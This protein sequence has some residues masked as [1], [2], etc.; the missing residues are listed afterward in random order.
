MKTCYHCGREFMPLKENQKFCSQSC[1]SKSARGRRKFNLSEGVMNSIT[2]YLNPLP[3]STSSMSTSTSAVASDVRN[4]AVKNA[5][6]Q[7]KFPDIADVVTTLQDQSV[8]IKSKLVLIGLV[9]IGSYAGAKL[10]G[11]GNRLSGGLAGGLL[12]A[13]GS[14]LL[15]PLQ[16]SEKELPVSTSVLSEAPYQFYT[17]NNLRGVYIPSLDFSLNT[18]LYQLIGGSLNERF[19]I[20]LYGIAGGGKSHLANLLACELSIVGRV[21]YVLAEEQITN[22]VQQRIVR[23]GSSDNVIFWVCS[24]E[25]KILDV[26]RG[27]DFLVLDSLNGMT[28]WNFHTDFLR[29]VKSLNLRGTILLTQMNKS[30]EFVGNNSLLH[31]VDVSIKVTDGIAETKKNRFGVSEGRYEIFGSKKLN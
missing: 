13:I 30:G 5:I 21:L 20:L 3:V 25:N 6:S 2:S 1:K 17:C 19:S 7:L 12:G 27:Y 22:S 4:M 23:Y 15:Y 16:R 28:Q 10:S 11:E 26:V 9:T 18:A 8:D 29:R 24:D 14:Q 31:E